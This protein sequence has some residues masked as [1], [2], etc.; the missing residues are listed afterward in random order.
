ME[1]QGQQHGSVPAEDV[2]YFVFSAKDY[3]LALPYFSII[4]IMDSP[5]CTAVPNMPPHVRGVIDFMGTGMA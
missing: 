2:D 4:Q 1:N 5:A 3:L